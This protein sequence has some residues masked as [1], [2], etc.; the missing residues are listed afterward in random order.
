MSIF[1]H[2]EN[3]PGVITEID[4]RLSS[5]YDTSLFGTTESICVVGTAFDGPVGSPFPVYSVEHAA[6]LY[7]KTYDSK[8]RREAS[9]VTGIKD[10]WDNGCRTIYALRING[11]DMYKDFEFVTSSDYKLRV[12][13]RYPSNLGKQTY[14]KYDNTPN[15]ESITI[16]KPASRATISEKMNGKVED[17]HSVMKVSIMLA[18]DY[19]F[20]ANSKLV[21]ILEIV[22]NHQD[23]NV[24]EIDIVDADGNVVTSSTEV[25]DL[26]LGHLFP[27]T[28]FIGRQGTKCKKET[29]VSIKIVFDRDKDPVPYT[30]FEGSCYR[31]LNKNTDVDQALP[32]HYTS[33]KE[34]RKILEE[35]G[36]TINAQDDYLE[37]PE[38]SNKAFPEDKMDYEETQLSEFEKYQRLGEGFAITA[39]AERRVDGDGK[40][41]TP[42]VKEAKLDDPQRIVPTGEGAYSILQDTKIR[43]HVMAHDICADTVISGKIPKHTAFK[44]TTSNDVMLLNGLVKATAK[45]SS[46]DET[47]ARKY[48]F[49]IY[50][51]EDKPQIT[52]D[53]LY[54]ER[55][56]EMV[57]SVDS[58]DKVKNLVGGKPGDKVIVLS[59]TPVMYIADEKGAYV[60]TNDKEL[61]GKYI[62]HETEKYG[63][64]LYLAGMIP[65]VA[66]FEDNTLGFTTISNGTTETGGK[67]HVIM[68]DGSNVFITSMDNPLEK[69]P[70]MATAD[71]ALAE[72]SEDLYVYFQDHCVGTNFV[73]ISY[74]Y[75]DTLTMT[76]FVEML[77]KSDLGH[78]FDFELTQAGR[79]LK[80]EYVIDA[81]LQAVE[82][83]K[84]AGNNEAK[85]TFSKNYDVVME[86]DR[87][88]GYDYSMHIPYYTTDNFARHLAQHCT[89]TE[90]NSFGTVGIIGCNRISDLSK[91]NLA[92]KINEMKE[93]NWNLFVKNN[94]GRNILNENNLPCNIGRNVMVT[95]FQHV[96]VTP[97]NFSTIVNGSTA[98]A[99]MISSMPVSQ[100]PTG[101]PIAI[102]PM[103]EFSR[104]QLQTLSK[105]GII[106]A[107]NS[108]TQG[109][110]ITDGVT[111]ASHDDVLRRIFNTR[112]MH[113]V[114]DAIRAAC[115]PFIGKGNTSVNRNSLNTAITS[116]LQALVG[117]YLRKFEFKIVDDGTA[118]QFT[119]LQ[120]YHTIVP[121]NE[122]REIRN[123]V[124]VKN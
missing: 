97:S 96:T 24:I 12:K 108:F 38:E 90:L 26:T 111:M 92:K 70:F 31:V 74:P 102:E 68:Q 93:F 66:S 30:D 81:D 41:L 54:E 10:A 56:V 40:E 6:Y 33:L 53:T 29:D 112:V 18:Q 84:T 110:T 88:R 15:L 65:V 19:A 124:H 94:F 25:Y 22:N 91:A 72:E 63:K 98:F 104:N 58:E 57:G 73:M 69:D 86:S 11:K 89:Y 106:T 43:Y 49:R 118:D 122:I 47:M 55:V 61:A 27:G 34:M 116:R 85:P 21:D 28:Y 82:D 14:F 8:T 100:S 59:D 60:K 48:N 20:N 42:K 3:L 13:S 76:D 113:L 105:L 83:S 17:E 51:Y 2:D 16:Y 52:K 75:F 103:F 117:N 39:V 120:I 4:S 7:G 80:D 9:L 115:E 71:V 67:P 64:K 36:I 44:K 121:V 62:E 95:L 119:Y 45:V 1:T 5:N 50:K 35:V 32:I 46:N 99:G 78:V 114:E 87:V 107:K 79:I 101:Q 123:V 77:N 109:Y 37:I 23:N